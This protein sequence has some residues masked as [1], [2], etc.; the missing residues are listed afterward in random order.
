MIAGR[1]RSWARSSSGVGS[2]RS[3]L[4]KGDE[5]PAEDT[6]VG[7]ERR[8]LRPRGRHRRGRAHAQVRFPLAG[9]DEQRIESG[10]A[11]QMCVQR[12]RAERFHRRRIQLCQRALVFASQEQ[13][14]RFLQG[15]RHAPVFE[16]QRPEGL[17]DAL[18]RGAGDIEAAHCSGV[19][20]AQ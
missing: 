5:T 11:K 4:E 12:H 15:D 1:A 17:E 13:R 20:K 19:P 3:V 8:L 10:G 18:E 16:R 14:H 9:L 7:L 2:R 6:G